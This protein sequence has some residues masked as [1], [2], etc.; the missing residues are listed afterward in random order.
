MSIYLTN[1][2]QLFWNFANGDQFFV[3][4][5]PIKLWEVKIRIGKQCKFAWVLQFKHYE[6]S[7]K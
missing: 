4:D 5:I 3:V 2:S 6:G 7:G 1:L